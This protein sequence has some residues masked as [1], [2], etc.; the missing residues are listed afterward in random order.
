MKE[1]AQLDQELTIEERNLLSVAYK[2]II[3]R[4]IVFIRVVRDLD[5]IAVG[6]RSLDLAGLRLSATS[7]KGNG[8]TQ[9][10]MILLLAS[11]M[12]GECIC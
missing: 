10:R 1:V 2:N 3:V 9:Q 4:A 8:V 7:N 6:S 11:W 5:D 12:P